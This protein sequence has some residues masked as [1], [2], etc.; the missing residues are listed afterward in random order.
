MTLGQKIKHLREQRGLYQKD[1][2]DKL[3]IAMTTLSGYERDAR[4][5]DHETLVKIGE[6]F[7][8]TIDFLLGTESQLDSLEE[9]FPEGIKML[10]R[11]NNE[12][13]TAQ[14]KKLVK[15]MEFMLEQ[16]KGKN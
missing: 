9:S 15:Y 2:S 13:N 10:R 7:G 16:E 4:K 6:F 14:K 1:I 8:V 11:A 12:M 5:P 3:G